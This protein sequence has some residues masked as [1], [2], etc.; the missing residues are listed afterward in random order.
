M[1]TH[2][3]LGP[4]AIRDY[5][6]LTFTIISIII[7]HSVASIQ[8][9]NNPF[10]THIQDYFPASP[11][12]RFTFRIKSSTPALAAIPYA[13]NLHRSNSIMPSLFSRG[14]SKKDKRQKPQPLPP[15]STTLPSR[16]SEVSGSLASPRPDST[17]FRKVNGYRQEIGEFGTTPIKPQ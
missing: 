7:P 3:Q 2:T 9:K 16:N 17:T 12:T 4:L 11:T 8:R 6:Q 10:D 14:G 1:H 13:T 5:Y 15:Q